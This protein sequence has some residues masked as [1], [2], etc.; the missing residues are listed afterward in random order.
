MSFPIS[1]GVQIITA[2]KKKQDLYGI[3]S[4]CETVTITAYQCGLSVW[5][6]PL[7]F[8]TDYRVTVQRGSPNSISTLEGNGIRRQRVGQGRVRNSQ[9]VYV[10]S[11]V[12][13]QSERTLLPVL[14]KFESSLWNFEHLSRNVRQFHWLHRKLS[15]WQF[16][17][18]PLSKIFA[19]V[20]F[21]F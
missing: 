8:W 9:L 4:S 20:T 12:V 7:D 5:K 11:W 1:L 6:Q 2:I 17:W 19:N 18:Q 15:F 14:T 21:P 13:W 3:T 10:R 16:P